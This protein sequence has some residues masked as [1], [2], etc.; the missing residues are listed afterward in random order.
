MSVDQPLDPKLNPPQSNLAR[1]ERAL[2]SLQ[3]LGQK[4]KKLFLLEGF[5][6]VFLV[7][8]GWVIVSF[9]I[10]YL[11]S[12]PSFVRG[13][14]LVGGSLILLSVFWK[15]VVRSS[16]GA[17]TL[18]ELAGLVERSQPQLNQALITAVQLTKKS[19]RSAQYLSQPLI[20][21]VVQKVEENVSKIQF[22][23]IFQW[24][25]FK[26][27]GLVLAFFS[28]QIFG[29]ALS[30]SDLA[31]VWLNRLVFLGDRSWPKSVVLEMVSPTENPLTIALGDEIPVEVAVLKGNPEEIVLK[32][33]SAG[34]PVREE[35]LWA[36]P[37]GGFRTVLKDFTEDFTFQ[38][39][40]GDAVLEPRDVK[41]QL[42]PKISQLAVWCEYPEY[43]G[44]E[45]TPTNEPLRIGH[46]RVPEKTQVRFRA[47]SDVKVTQAFFRWV[48]R[49]RG[50]K[51]VVEDGTT[52]PPPGSRPLDIQ[53]L[54]QS[55]TFIPVEPGESLSGSGFEGQFEVT[56]RGYYQFHLKG[57]EGL[58]NPNP[59]SFR[60]E[61]I[62]DRPPSVRV[63]EPRRISEEISPEAVFSIQVRVEDD[64]GI[65]G[66]QLEGMH[67]ERDEQKVE[68]GK[69]LVLPF[70]SLSAENPQDS[71]SEPKE[72]QLLFDSKKL[73]LKPGNRVH[74]TVMATDFGNKVGRSES[75]VFHVVEKQEILQILYDR[76]SLVRDQIVTVEKRQA[77]ARKDFEGLQD[78]VATQEVI[79][80]DR[81][82]RFIRSRQDQA[83]VSLGIR[84]ARD[85]VERI[86][87]KMEAN[88]V[89]DEK[90][91]A[92]VGRLESSLKQL[93]T[94]TSPQVEK[95]IQTIRDRIN[96]GQA[97]PEELT[98]VIEHQR[99][100]GREL[101]TLALT[102]MEFGDFNGILQ[103][104]RDLLRREEEILE[105]I[106]ERIRQGTDTR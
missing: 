84:R 22:N 87:M 103:R 78:D 76:L 75:Y 39:S 97:K 12:L 52:F 104:W 64:Y 30:R 81:A 101:N 48:P 68:D 73:Q 58:V 102:L 8:T 27:K 74:F 70:D 4:A 91:K 92:W 85:S 82:S 98:Q 5:L 72:A 37:D 65:Q 67:V 19:H 32:R 62:D 71:D 79:A 25:R 41:V 49:P 50:K 1:P 21:R 54:A 40:G 17:P 34:S 57:D 80:K 26:K 105:D 6:G 55:T 96:E 45:A 29:I 66:A 2:R 10:D 3:A 20:E 93:A 42:R 59:V 61:V 13:V 43:T 90:E 23:R 53:E 77:S 44:R 106:R 18:E 88:K 89:G 33:W 35:V 16:V 24:D 86:L 47:S 31:E 56:E 11:L 83:R 99:R 94:E 14:F 7:L 51:P 46:L 69:T 63:L 60:V 95:E 36:S 15:R 28:I 9:Y 100:I 38:I